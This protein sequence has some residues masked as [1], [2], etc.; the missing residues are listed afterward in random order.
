MLGKHRRIWLLIIGFSFIL[1]LNMASKSLLSMVTADINKIDVVSGDLKKELNCTSVTL[2][3]GDVAIVSQLA[4]GQ[5]GIATIQA[6]PYNTK[7]GFQRITNSKGTYVIPTDISLDKL[8][9]ELFNVEYLVKEGYDKMKSL[10]V[11]VTTSTMEVHTQQSIVKCIQAFD[12][13]LT[14]SFQGISTLALD[15]PMRTLG[16]SVHNLLEQPYVKK[17]WLDKK[18]HVCLNDSVPLIGVPELWNAGYNGTGIQIA[19]IDTG[20]DDT[21]PDL[22][23]LDDNPNTFDPKVIR[24]V[25]FSNDDTTDDLH[26][27]G[28]H[29]AGIAAGTGAMSGGK[30]RGVAPGAKLWNV[31]VLNQYGWGDDSWVVAGINYAAYGPDGIPHSGDE[32]DVISMSLGGDATDGSDPA[33]LAVDRAVRLGVVVVIAVGNEGEYLQIRSPG[34]AKQA[35]SVGA[36]FKQDE[37][38]TFSSRGP[39]LDYRVKPDVLAPGVFINSTVPE[40]LTGAYYQL[41]SGTSMAA[42]HVAGSAALLLQAVGT[43]PANLSLPS[44]VKDVLISTAKDLGY[45]VYTQGGG[46]IYLPSAASTDIVA[47]PATISFSDTQD[48]E[49]LQNATITFYNLNATSSHALNLNV[50]VIDLAGNTVNCAELNATVLNIAPNSKVAVLLTVNMSCPSQ[51]YSGKIYAGVDGKTSVHV[52]F[53]IA[54]MNHVTITVR[55]KY[56]F[57][58]QDRTVYVVGDPGIPGFTWLGAYP[59]DNVSLSVISG[60]YHILASRVD[61]S[62]NATI[63]TIADHVSITSD[64]NITL[65]EGKTFKIDLN[66]NKPNQIIAD[67]WVAL[68]L[69]NAYLFEFGGIIYPGNTVTYVSATSLHTSYSYCYYPKTYYDASDRW[70]LNTPEWNNLIYGLETISRNVTLT[71]DYNNLVQR[72]ADYKVAEQPGVGNIIQF[73][74][75]SGTYWHAASGFSNDLPQRRVEW[76]S[77]SPACQ[78][79]VYGSSQAGFWTNSPLSYPAKSKPYIAYGEHPLVSGLSL[80]MAT[81]NFTIGDSLCAD[82]FGNEYESPGDL[83]IFTGDAQVFH[84][85]I[86]GWFLLIVH[87][88]GI[89]PIKVVTRSYGGSLPLSKNTTTELSFTTDPTQDCQP[90]KIKMNVKGSDLG[91]RVPQGEVLVNVTVSDESSLTSTSLEYS[92][93]DGGTWSGAITRNV[94]GNIYQFSLRTV[95]DNSYV[96]LRFNATDSSGNR[97]SQTAIRGVL[98]KD[99]GNLNSDRQVDGKDLAIVAKAYNTKPGQPLWNSLADTNLDRKIDGLDIA[100]IAS[101]FGRKW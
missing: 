97:V 51:L 85:T 31:K 29:C 42:P 25:N 53:G 27:H 69:K 92:I 40:N 2:V 50:S 33:S 17:I 48:K 96:S 90:P 87:Y 76:L 11:M 6:D 37:I 38:A 63:V 98:V 16:N 100:V 54:N 32:A 99:L 101:H 35:I 5:L 64:M 88:T 36:S 89:L 71:A 95:Y 44:Y 9:I 74:S 12:G 49:N 34:C 56:G 84:M 68:S 86:K 39:T 13:R 28:T 26:S 1:L 94:I 22:D 78:I 61:F 82:T 65:D 57:P 47:D 8:D 66:P 43:L 45:D 62:T 77:P 21:H 83:A 58:V 23:D 4:E 79:G 3:T 18:V 81:E 93:D 60:V 91:C 52:I 67:K 72:T 20:I 14:A 46:R 7:R 30:N 24:K 80:N 19:I 59:S 10:P 55:N 73:L 75:D 15:L 41:K 70:R